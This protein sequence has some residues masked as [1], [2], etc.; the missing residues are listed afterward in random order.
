[1]VSAAVDYHAAPRE[2]ALRFRAQREPR[3]SDP[4]EDAA[5]GVVL[6]VLGVQGGWVEV[7]NPGSDEV[8]AHHCRDPLAGLDPFRLRFFVSAD[9]LAPVLARRFTHRYPDG[10]AIDLLPGL[11]LGGGPP[12]M[13][14]SRR[15]FGSLTARLPPAAIALSY[16]AAPAPAVARFRQAADAAASAEGSEIVI[17]GARLRAGP[18]SV[19]TG[20]AI[21]ATPRRTGG[22]VLIDLADRCALVTARAAPEDVGAFGIGGAAVAGG[23]QMEGHVTDHDSRYLYP[24]VE[25][26][27]EDGSP[28][29]TARSA[30]R[31][32]HWR[33]HAVRR[34]LACIVHDLLR[35]SATLAPN[36]PAARDRPRAPTELTLCFRYEDTRYR[37]ED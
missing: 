11:P 18:H 35:P 33:P 1:M 27:W 19:V 30:R 32:D 7:E 36:E 25:L 29:G 34:E 23:T 21:A 31:Y 16:P 14:T 17:G 15:A 12:G 13:Q 4:A 2:D 26:F 20:Q 37:P 9:A 10:T 6:R 28:A 8:A 5:R 3:S 22:A 24:G